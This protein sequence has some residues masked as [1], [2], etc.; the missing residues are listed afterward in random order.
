MYGG[1]APGTWAPGVPVIRRYMG[2]ISYDKKVQA[3]IVAYRCTRCGYLELYA[4]EP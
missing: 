4:G 2:G 3:Q 1:I